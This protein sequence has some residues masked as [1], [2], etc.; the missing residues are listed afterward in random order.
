MQRKEVVLAMLAAF[1]G[2]ASAQSSVTIYG[3]VDMATKFASAVTRSHRCSP[4]YALVRERGG[5]AL[6]L[7]E[8]YTEP[9]MNF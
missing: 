7:A 8:F 1:S 6:K 2:V 4:G 5:L 3:T 9:W